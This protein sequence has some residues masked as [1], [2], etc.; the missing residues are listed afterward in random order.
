MQ[1]T[2][3]PLVQ[4]PDNQNRYKRSY[5]GS[6][7]EH[8]EDQC[9]LYIKYEKN[10]P[11]QKKLYAK[12]QPADSRGVEPAFKRGAFLFI[13][14]GLVGKNGGGEQQA[15]DADPDDR[16]AQVQPDVMTG[17]GPA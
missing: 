3:A 6:R 8:R 12:G 16:V 1:A 14:P 17:G 10:N 7:V 15:C 13:S 11:H 4:D 2:V 9:D 5:L